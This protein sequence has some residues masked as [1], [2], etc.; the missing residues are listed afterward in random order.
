MFRLFELLIIC[1][2]LYVAA[3]LVR[4]I[5]FKTS[6]GKGFFGLSDW[7]IKDEEKKG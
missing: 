3:N 4:Y 6:K 5:F 2:F 1:G 7:W